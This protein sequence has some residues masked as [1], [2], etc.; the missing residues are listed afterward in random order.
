MLVV[1][2]D[3]SFPSRDPRGDPIP[4]TTTVSAEWWSR[5]SG[6]L[7]DDHR[8]EVE[9]HFG[10]FFFEGEDLTEQLA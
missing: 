10:V 4:S 7:F 9:H 1:A 8:D 6:R 5:E 2:L 3:T